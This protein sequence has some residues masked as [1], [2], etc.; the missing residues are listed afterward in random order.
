MAKSKT[1]FLMRLALTWGL[2]WGLSFSPISAFAQKA[3]DQ[4]RIGLFDPVSSILL[5]DDSQPEIGFLSRAVF[6]PL[7]CF[8]K[9][10]G[11]FAPLLASSW[12]IVDDKT[13]EFD[14]RQDV[15]FH[16][17]SPFSADDIVYT[18]NWLTA[19][20]TNFRFKENFDWFAGIEKLGD[21][22][23]R[24]SLKRPVGIAMIRLAISFA[25]LP[26]KLHQ[27]LKEKA[28]FG[29]KTPIGTGPYKAEYVDANR[30]VSLIR[31]ADYKQ[32]NDCKSAARVSRIKAL[33]IPDIQTQVAQMNTG[34][35][36]LL[37]V[38][39]KD[40]V[41]FL[42]SNPAYAVTASQAITFHYMAMDSINRSGNQA[43]SNPKVRQAL[44]Q[45][46]DRGLVAKTVVPGGDE[47]KQID[48]LCFKVQLGCAYS[49]KPPEFDR[50]AARK[51][52]AEAG[53]PNGFDT[54]ITATPGS[55]DLGD[56]LAG[57]LR[58]INV[59][60]KVDKVTFVAY[61]QKQRDGKLQLLVGQW[62]SGGVPD[63]SSSVEFYFDRGARDYWRDP[64]IEK[65]ADEASTISDE[66]KRKEVYSKIFDRANEARYIL[67]IS[68]KP[69]VF[70]HIKD[71][72]VARGSLSVYGADA[73]E[74]SWK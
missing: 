74:L 69:D 27:P 41:D 70:V 14:L 28:E 5:Y 63:A 46:I 32:G 37:H 61:R 26:A 72:N 51:L 54:E 1:Q 44:M 29:R 15:K 65:W 52:L 71:L 40:I 16:D 24:M 58:K 35:L 49:T 22:K 18:M 11:E 50:E 8:D 21:Y 2:T 20:D 10:T 48:A 38:P 33:P 23:V 9:K 59:R 13:L 62:T 3:V 67:P 34:G 36:D 6:D 31:N 57:E 45:A 30:G 17:G 4:V 73:S 12:K 64:Q 53:Y 68:T 56:A 7:I 60:A 42:G 19:A 55:Y 66:T 39:S 25:V 43:L 47:V